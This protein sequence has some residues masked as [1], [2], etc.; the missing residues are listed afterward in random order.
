MVSIRN[1][2]LKDEVK[3]FELLKILFSNAAPGE[4]V[5]DWSA[6][7]KEFRRI[8][9]DEAKGN[10]IVAEENGVILGLVTV[11]YI[12]AIRCAGIYGSIEEFVV[13][14]AARGKGV[15]GRLLEAV[16]EKA[17]KKGCTDI[18]VN[19]PS[20]LGYPVYLRNG[21]NDAGKN[22]MMKLPRIS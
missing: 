11:S 15:G 20:Q 10:V 18:I 3:V 21:F 1:A 5:D 8:T 4:R 2:T 13:S 9:K 12:E 14:E 6:M 7:A 16:V 19:R 17:T 22:L